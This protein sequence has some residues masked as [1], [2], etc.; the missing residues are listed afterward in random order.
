MTAYY[1]LMLKL[2]DQRV[3]VIGGGSI[4][5]RKITGLLES[6]ASHVRVI[7]PQLIEPLQLLADDGLIEWHAQVYEASVLRTATLVFA[8]TDDTKLNDQISKD[9]MKCDILVC[10]VSDGY[11]GN[12]I[13][14]AIARSGELVAAISSAGS[15][16]SLVKAMKQ[17][18]EQRFLPRYANAQQL[19][20]QLRAEVLRSNLNTAQRKQLLSIAAAEVLQIDKSQYEDW[21][22]SLYDRIVLDEGEETED[23][24]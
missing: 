7:A 16:P 17:E 4:A 15:S 8:A 5:A 14:P 2:N 9:A 19:M 23:G 20:K 12:F 3:A 11:Q 6:G 22:A 10:N 21:H 1:P 18:L 13:T 24:S